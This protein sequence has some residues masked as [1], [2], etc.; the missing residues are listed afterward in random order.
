MFDQSFLVLACVLS[1]LV[2]GSIIAL[3]F[4]KCGFRPSQYLSLIALFSF[5]VR[6]FATA[7]CDFFVPFYYFEPG[8][9]ADGVYLGNGAL[10][11]Y[12]MGL[13]VAARRQIAVPKFAL[14][15]LALLADFTLIV[16]VVLDLV[17]LSL[18]GTAI[19]PGVR[20]TGLQQAAAGSQIFFAMVSGLT[21]VGFGLAVACAIIQPRGMMRSLVRI[22]GFFAISMLFYQRGAL[23]LGGVLGLMIASTFDP[24]FYTKR[25]GRTVAVLV[26]LVMVAMFARPIIT[27]VVTQFEPATQVSGSAGPVVPQTAACSIANV[28]NQE[29]DQVWPT[30]FVFVERYGPDYFRNIAAA[31]LRPFINADERDNLGFTTSVDSLNLYNDAQSYLDFN[32]GFSIS[33]FQY[34]YYSVGY[35][36]LIMVLMVGFATSYVEN[37]MGNNSSIID[38]RLLIRSLLILNFVILFASPVDEQLKWAVTNLVISLTI[39]GLFR[40][41]RNIGRSADAGLGFPAKRL[42]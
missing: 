14:A 1:F 11:L 7:Q 17:T 25:A 33:S 6:P 15:E 32:F 29:H 9:Y 2:N 39:I 5:A 16:A 18:F 30:T 36:C 26:L 24:R 37:K 31:F 10:T 27:A 23:L 8:L 35:F 21:V 42:G 4:M 22:V 19:L 40:L 34:Y 13:L 12:N 38:S 28:A 20:T 3:L 41:L